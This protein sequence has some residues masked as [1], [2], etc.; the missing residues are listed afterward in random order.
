MDTLLEGLAWKEFQTLIGTVKSSGPVSF[1]IEFYEFQTLI[2]TVKSLLLC[3]EEVPRRKFQTL[4]GTVKSPSATA[5]SP[6]TS[7]RF[8][9]S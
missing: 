8:K 3:S 4:I 7:T 2:G 1:L 9:P 6:A 5:F